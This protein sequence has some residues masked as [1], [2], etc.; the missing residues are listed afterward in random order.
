M[1]KN[2]Y[3]DSIQQFFLDV[4]FVPPP[5]INI[6]SLFDSYGE[7]RDFFLQGDE[8]DNAYE[9]V[10]ILLTDKDSQNLFSGS[11]MLKD[12]GFISQPNYTDSAKTSLNK[13]YQKKDLSSTHSFSD[14]HLEGLE[15]EVAEFPKHSAVKSTMEPSVFIIQKESV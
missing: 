8:D 10:Q 14:E 15:Q 4:G 7:P 3:E 2:L 5:N 9:G 11:F 12:Q 13:E 1:S 6:D